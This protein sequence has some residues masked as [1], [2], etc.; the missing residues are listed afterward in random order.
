ML[1][2][3][4]KA[5]DALGGMQAG[6]FGDRA[7]PACHSLDHC[8]FPLFPAPAQSQPNARRIC[9]TSGGRLEAIRCASQRLTFSL[10][11]YLISSIAIALLQCSFL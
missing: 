7:I 3:A 10:E 11:G 1:T 2:S 9:A 4:K 6:D 8:G 5:R